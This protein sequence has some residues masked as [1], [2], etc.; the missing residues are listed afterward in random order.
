MAT[1]AIKTSKL[2]KRYG[3]VRGIERLDLTVERGEVFGFL[4]PNG[5]G[6]STTINLLMGFRRPTS[7]TV[8]VLG[9]AAGPEQVDVRRRI[10]Y[11]PGE[12]ALY[13]SMKGRDLLEYYG[14]LR[15]NF[16][17]TYVAE[18]AERLGLDL[19]RRIKALS[20]GNKQK[21]ALVAAF[22][23]R[24]ELLVLDEPTS[25]LDP[26]VQQE[27]HQLVR[28]VRK[29]GATVFLSSHV[30]SEV[31]HI[32]DRAAIIKEGRL[33]ALERISSLRER[34]SR[35][36]EIRFVGPVPKTLAAVANVSDVRVEQGIAHCRVHGAVDPLIK[37]L[38]RHRVKS[39]VVEHASLEVDVADA[40]GVDRPAE[41]VA[42]EDQEHDREQRHRHQ[43]VAAAQDMQRT[44]LGHQPGIAHE[45]E[46]RG[47]SLGFDPVG[48]EVAHAATFLD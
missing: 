16:D 21:V 40:A 12:L 18:L 36:V 32:C 5:A 41:D 46:Q 9:Q 11:M 43:L 29:T 30:L 48:R 44:P 38:A 4:G 7:G 27:F 35:Q 6:K 47:T 14:N 34:A 2:T 20:K 31:E 39:L 23:N 1:P 28:E 37:F 8:K 42:V 45:P 10:G 33:V 25:G 15:G 19:T 17:A 22:M 26:I 24:P 13:E 3:K